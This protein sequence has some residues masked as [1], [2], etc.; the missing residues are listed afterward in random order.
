[1]PAARITTTVRRATGSMAPTSDDDLD[2]EQDD[3]G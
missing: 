1:M 3:D 2:D